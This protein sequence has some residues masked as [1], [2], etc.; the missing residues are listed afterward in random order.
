[1]TGK[2]ARAS[3]PVNLSDSDIDTPGYR[4]QPTRGF[5]FAVY[6]APPQA[7]GHEK[8]KASPTTWYRHAMGLQGT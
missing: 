1:M 2:A 7:E 4:T 6:Q 3:L 8:Q 5:A